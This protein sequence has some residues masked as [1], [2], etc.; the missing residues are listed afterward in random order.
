MEIVGD[1]TCGLFDPE[2]TLVF[3]ITI[4]GSTVTMELVIPPPEGEP[5]QVSTDSYDPTDN[6]VTLEGS[7]LNSDYD[8]PCVVEL[9]DEFELTLDDP[10]VSLDENTTVQV[11][12]DH[13]EIDVSETVGDCAGEWFVDL[14]CSGRATLTLTQD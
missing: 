14:P 10:D 2:E 7:Q 6:Q 5:L 1:D 13:D 4:E 11:T 3:E 9:N 12:W 8:P